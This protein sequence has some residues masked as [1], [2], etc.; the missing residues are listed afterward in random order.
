MPATETSQDSPPRYLPGKSVI[1][2]RL[3]AQDWFSA[4]RQVN[5]WWTLEQTGDFFNRD[6]STVMWAI[7]RHADL[8]LVEPEYLRLWTEVQQDLAAHT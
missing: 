1:L 7:R 5:T 6:H 4:L 3:P 8:L 2:S